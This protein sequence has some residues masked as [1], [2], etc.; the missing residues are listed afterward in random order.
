MDEIAPRAN[1]HLRRHLAAGRRTH[2]VRRLQR[3]AA[4]CIGHRSRHQGRA[5]GAE[6]HQSR[7]RQDRRVGGGLGGADE[8]RCFFLAR[9]IG[10]YAG[11]RSA[12]RR[13]WCSGCA[14]RASRRSCRRP[15]RSRSASRTRCCAS[16]PSPCR[17]IRSPPTPTAAASRWG[18][19]NS[20]TSCGRRRWIRHRN[21]AWAI[22]RRNWP[23]ATR[24]R[25]R[26]PTLRRTSF[27]RAVAAREAGY[28]T[29]EIVPVV[30]EQFERAG[31]ETRGI[32]LPRGVKRLRPTSIRVRRRSRR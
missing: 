18:R 1:H 23:S 32:R 17:A 22:R 30:S 31:Y 21:R 16:A 24:S 25:A 9:H 11:C 2:A 20:R 28:F 4:R 26:I 29:D 12:C 14:P 13:S 27:E 3:H 6:R 7:A 15:T 5:R 8:L 10:L 19:W